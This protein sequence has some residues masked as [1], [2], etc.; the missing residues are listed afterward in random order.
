[1]EKKIL[2]VPGLNNSGKTHWQTIWESTHPDFERVEQKDWEHPVR[3]EWV[4]NIEAAVRKNRG[5]DIYIVAHSLGCIATVHWANQT[6]QTI[7]G[8][9]LVAPPDVEG[10]AIRNL[11]VGFN[12]VPKVRL[13]FDS[14]VVASENDEYIDI[15]SSRL[16]AIYWGSSFVNIGKKGH[17]NANS[18]LNQWPAGLRLLKALTGIKVKELKY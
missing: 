11:I 13:L 2:I 5:K 1:M 18:G 7:K 10:E 16:L 4:K 12:P 15:N 8:A 14:I 3:N 6:S 9:L 17:I